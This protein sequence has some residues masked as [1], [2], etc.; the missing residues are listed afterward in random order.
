MLEFDKVIKEIKEYKKKSSSYLGTVCSLDF[1]WRNGFFPSEVYNLDRS[2]AIEIL[3]RLLYF[4]D[5]TTTYPGG[6]DSLEEWRQ[7]LDNMCNEF[8]NYIFDEDSYSG[9]IINPYIKL[10]EYI[11]VLWN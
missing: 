4:R 11:P 9:S 2:I 6:F 10:A 3:P 7:E 1:Y 8:Y 5:K